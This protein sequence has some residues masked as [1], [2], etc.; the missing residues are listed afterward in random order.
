MNAGKASTMKTDRHGNP[1]APG[2]PY[3]R[4]ELLSRTED[5][6]TKLGEAWRMIKSQIA[7]GG[8]DAVFNF[9]GLERHLPCP[10]DDIGLYDDELAPALFGDRLRELGLEHLGGDAEMHDIAVM[11]RTTAAVL[12][13]MLTLVEPG[14]TVIGVSASYSHPCVTRSAARAG[15]NFIDTTG[16]AEFKEV[17]AAHDNVAVVAMTRLAVTYEILSARDIEQIVDLAHGVGAKVIVDDAGGARVGPAIFDQPR[18]LEFGVDIAAT[19]LDKYGVYGPRV[20][21]MGG[22]ADIVKRARALSFELA[23]EA[24]PMLY[25]FVVHTLE[26]YDPESVRE[27]VRN[28][29]EVAEELKKR[30]GNR[31]TETPVTAQL[32]AEDILEMAMERANVTAAPI[33]PYEATAALAMLLVRDFGIMTVHLAGLPP[34]SS[35]LLIKFVPPHTL[36]RFGGAARFA[37]AIDS[38][39][40]SLS[41][42]VDNPE[43]LR[44]LLFGKDGA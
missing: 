42:I 28:T 5:D 23:L 34:G 29:I 4:G 33:V 21:L 36:E 38:S 3:A 44:E 27:L 11:N 22:T 7:E 25:P 1:H 20:G 30:L 6:I 35:P 16:L 14:D 10:T 31:V 8:S 9:S 37:E 41:A 2:V 17:L 24:R 39:I 19:G 18:I 15:A 32:L 26:Q 43:A 12:S 13:A 40:T